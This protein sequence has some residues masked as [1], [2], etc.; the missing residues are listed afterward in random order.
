MD[1]AVVAIDY[2]GGAAAEHA[3]RLEAGLKSKGLSVRAPHDATS[4]EGALGGLAEL[5]ITIVATGL[6]KASAK[7]ALDYLGE[8]LHERIEAADAALRIRVVV[9]RPGMTSRKIP[10]SI[11]GAPL[12]TADAF[13]AEVQ[14]AIESI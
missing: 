1:E 6:A 13:L 5:I 14:K 11:E 3:A 9:P 10:F 4:A 8:F 2:V 7:L 12:A